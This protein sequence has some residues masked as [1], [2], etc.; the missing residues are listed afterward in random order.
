[1]IRNREISELKDKLGQE[2][3]YLEEEIRSELNLSTLLK[4]PS[5]E[6]GF[7]IGGDGRIQRFYCAAA[8]RHGDGQG[9]DRARYSRPQPA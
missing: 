9:V 4:H 7:G 6:E 5:P 2:K 1:M 3:L 8:G